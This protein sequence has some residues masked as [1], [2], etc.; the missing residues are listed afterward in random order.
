MAAPGSHVAD[1]ERPLAW[2]AAL[3]ADVLRELASIAEHLT[4]TEF[5]DPA[6][7]AQ[8]LAAMIEIGTRP[9]IGWY[10]RHTTAAPRRPPSTDRP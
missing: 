8:E 1:Q 2:V 10:R 5:I 9:T 4:R 6:R 3:P 7:A